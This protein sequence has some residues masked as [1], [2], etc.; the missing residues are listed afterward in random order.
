M[1]IKGIGINADAE[2]LDGDLEKLDQ[3]LTYFEQIGFDYVEIPS[4]GVNAVMNGVPFWP[5]IRRVREIT[6]RHKLR[7]TV[8]GPNGL[9]LAGWEDLPKQR[10]VFEGCLRFCAEI[11]AEVM[12]YHSGMMYLSG[13]AYRAEPLP[14]RAQRD[15]FWRTEVE[16]LQRMAPL[17]RELGV[18]IAVENRDPHL[19]EFVALRRSAAA[20]EE[21]PVYHPGLL[22]S[23]LAH[24]VAE[25]NRPE[26]GVTL[27]MGHA[28]IAAKMCGF[29]Y[30]DGVRQ[31]APYVF[32]I[33]AHDNFGLLDG[34]RGSQMERLP[35]GEADLHL[36]PGWGEIPLTES[37]EALGGY[38]GVIVLEI[39]PR[40]RAFY[41]EALDAT[42]KLIGHLHLQSSPA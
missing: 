5:I 11:E 26:I 35:N 29:D 25:I 14:D 15:W 13:T 34:P 12:V 23:N 21:L 18:K 20:D 4:H 10:A 40:Y 8:H 32:H 24:Q 41:A 17:A 6:R 1:V 38:N 36:P 27:D 28:Y 9:T 7:Y 33:H 19:W 16:E 30:L 2:E 39:R 31:I 3:E 42:R 37:L 22:L